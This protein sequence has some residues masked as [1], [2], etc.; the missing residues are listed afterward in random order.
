[1]K[2]DLEILEDARRLLE[3]GADVELILVF[4]RDRGFQK[5]ES[6]YALRNLVGI[7]PSE[8]KNLV[9]LSQAWSDMYE[10]D[11]RLRETAREALRQ[12]AAS[13]SP[14]LPRTIFDERGNEWASRTPFIVR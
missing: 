13:N 14:D 8:A 10:T 9:D 4:L 1:M 6:N 7:N 3:A 2:L 12:L 11:M 5:I